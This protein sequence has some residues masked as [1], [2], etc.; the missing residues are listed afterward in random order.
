MSNHTNSS[1]ET[2]DQPDSDRHRITVET[3][4]DDISTELVEAVATL[5]DADLDE[6]AVLSEFVNPDALNTLFGPQVDGTPR[7]TDGHVVFTYDSHHVRVDSDG[8]IT[9]HQGEPNADS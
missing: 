7:D 9:L 4:T 5:N 2:N 1:D 3:A 8:T 6:L